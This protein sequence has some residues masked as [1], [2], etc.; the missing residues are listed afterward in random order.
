MKS[1][2]KFIA[3]ATAGLLTF[4][5][6]APALSVPVLAAEESTETYRIFLAFGGD[7]AEEGDWAY[8]YAGGDAT[9]GVTVTDA[10]IK[11]GDTARIGL[12]F[13]NPV[14]NAWYFAPTIIA[15]SVIEADFSVKAF[16]DG[17]EVSV[18]LAAGDNWWYEG[19]GDFTDTQAIR[20]AGGFNEWGT[21]YMSE[22]SGFTKLEF[23]VTANSIKVGE[24]EPAGEAVESTEEYN[25]Y[26]AFGG[27][28]VEENDWA[29]SYA[30]GE[31]SEGITAT[32]ATIKVGETASVKLEFDDPVVNAW[33]FAPFIVAEN[34]VEADFSVKAFVDGN[35]VA[36]DLSAG[37]NWWYEGTGD[38]TDTQAVRIGGGFNE[39]GTQ[40]MA[41]PSGFKTLEF[42]ITANSIKVGTAAEDNAAPAAAAVDLDGTYNAYIGFQTPV[43]SFRNA[44]NDTTYGLGTDYFNQVTGWE[45]SDAVVLSGTFADAEIKGNGTY[46][47]SVD[48]LSFPAGEFDSQDYMNLIF[49]STDIPR[50]DAITVSDVML[51]IDGMQPSISPLISPEDDDEYL[52][53]AIQNIWNPD[54]ATIGFYT[55]PPTKMSVT[56]TLSGFNYDNP[57]EAAAE[58]T[59]EEPEAE[60]VT[61]EVTP[62]ADVAAEETTPAADTNANQSGGFPVVP[63]VIIA[64]IVVA[65]IIVGVVVYN[66]KK[67]DGSSQL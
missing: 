65:G 5:A 66:K 67:G 56:F 9:E 62:E 23:E 39:W 22:P 4:A 26:L 13:A 20:V 33:Y 49:V 28:K 37:D 30:G 51:D 50:T 34:V 43:F 10:E 16:V 14:V 53:I 18:D 21:Q 48:G 45:G 25:M 52:T 57:D 58:E 27:D 29:Y 7:A 44:W 8:S 31:A 24:A 6:A 60:E 15:E 59:V 54:I 38:F 1:F 32:D 12:E 55:V 64:I 40:Y 36:V 11:V 17:N 3:A 41:E 63:V 19:T 46:T 35:E 61:E 47:V 42:E 2:K